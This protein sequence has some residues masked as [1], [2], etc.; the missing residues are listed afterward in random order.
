MNNGTP[1]SP[2]GSRARLG[3]RLIIIVRRFA[4]E[5]AGVNNVATTLYAG[6]KAAKRKAPRYDEPM[7]RFPDAG[8]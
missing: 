5:T 3:W 2:N 7:T 1:T 8:E 6:F 4:D